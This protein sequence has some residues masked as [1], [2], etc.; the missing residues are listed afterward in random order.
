MASKY[1]DVMTTTECLDALGR[2][3]QPQG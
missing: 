3:G 2:I 1:A